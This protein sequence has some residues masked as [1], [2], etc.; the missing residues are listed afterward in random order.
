MKF[1]KRLILISFISVLCFQVKAQ[2]YEV[3]SLYDTVPN[4]VLSS[5]YKEEMEKD[6]GR[7][8]WIIKVTD[9]ELWY[10]K[11]DTLNSTKSAVVIVPGGGYSGIAMHHEGIEVAKKF[12]ELGVSAF[13]LKY[14]LP[15][16]SIMKD[17]K[18]GPLQDAQKSLKFLRDHAT[19]FSIDPDKIGIMGFSAG[20]HLAATASTH[21]DRNFISNKSKTN[22][23]PDYSILIYPVI[24]FGA[25]THKG[26]RNNLIGKRSPQRDIDYFS[27]EQQVTEDTPVTF[28]VHANDDEAVPPE[29][30]LKYSTALNKKGIKNEVHLYPSGGHGFGLHNDAVKDQWFERLVLWLQDQEFLNL[31]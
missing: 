5:S 7:L 30:T 20:G 17:K 15:H 29:N 8:S 21:F 18:I 4:S 25:Y 10:F 6:K 23:R 31:D 2:E 13:V 26:S 28:M 12:N 16:D 11:P 27:N 22:L 24:T 19:K 3:F 1:V 9:P 14:R